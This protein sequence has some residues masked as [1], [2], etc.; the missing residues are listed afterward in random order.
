MSS[1][2]LGAS[3]AI[4][5]EVPAAV[6]CVTG[7][8]GSLTEALVNLIGNAV[9][10]THAGGSV[11]VRVAA[12][13]EAVVLSVADTGIDIPPEDLSMVFDAFYRAKSGAA[14]ASGAGLG[15]ALTR[16]I[17]EAHGG[18]LSVESEVGKGTTFSIR[19]PVQQAGAIG[20]APQPPAAST[21][22][23]G[24]TR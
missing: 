6:P 8:E 20:P 1:T 4:A 17:V 10:Y 7:D 3:G 2:R 19:L 18:T 11:A 9:K 15:L 23:T 5:T 22:P 13:P 24:D 14:A 16:R 21:R 12:A